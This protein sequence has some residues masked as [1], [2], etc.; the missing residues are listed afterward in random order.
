M[1]RSLRPAWWCRVGFSIA[2]AASPVLKSKITA[3]KQGPPC[4][5]IP[6]KL[7]LVRAFLSLHPLPSRYRPVPTAAKPYVERW[8]LLHELWAAMNTDATVTSDGV[9]IGCKCSYDW[10][11]RT[12]EI[13]TE[14]GICRGKTVCRK[15]RK[16]LMERPEGDAWNS[17]CHGS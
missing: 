17:P 3:Y 16:R 5:H 15:R 9:S 10:C 2:R 11:P 8:F 4:A 7:W 6:Y 1:E 13:R 14:I 12:E